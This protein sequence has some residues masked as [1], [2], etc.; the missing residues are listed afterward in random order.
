MNG[1]FNGETL[2]STSPAPGAYSSPDSWWKD[3]LGDLLRGATGKLEDVLELED[4]QYLYA[5]LPA[6]PAP[7]RASILP[8]GWG[9]PILIGGG[10]LLAYLARPR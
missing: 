9:L 4:E 10:L 3:P 2:A 5:E 1:G 7:A 6:A 8:S